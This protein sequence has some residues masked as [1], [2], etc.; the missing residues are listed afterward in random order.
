EAAAARAGERAL[1]DPGGEAGCDAGVDGAPP[2]RPHPRAGLGGDLVAGSDRASHQE[3]RLWCRL[4][5]RMSFSR[6]PLKRP[7]DTVGV[8]SIPINTSVKAHLEAVLPP[9]SVN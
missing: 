2:R 3:R 8:R 5:G 9:Y 4:T 1:G 7:V 6:V